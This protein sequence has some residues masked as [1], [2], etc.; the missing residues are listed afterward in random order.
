[1]CVY[2]YLKCIYPNMYICMYNCVIIICILCSDS[3]GVTAALMSCNLQSRV[4]WCDG[5]KA[6]LASTPH[7]HLPMLRWLF[8]SVPA[9][10]PVWPSV[11]QSSWLNVYV[12]LP[13]L[14]RSAPSAWGRS[15]HPQHGR[16][17]SPG[18]GRPLCQGR[19]HW[20]ALCFLSTHPHRPT[21]LQGPQ[22]S[23]G[24]CMYYSPLVV[25]KLEEVSFEV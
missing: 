6:L 1:M 15:Q 25:R 13:L 11:C 5:V 24:K 8:S 14:P 2:S 12:S 22:S 17:V 3:G 7:P 21:V 10:L 16:E 20:W 19:P 4:L 9:G 23:Q 18:P